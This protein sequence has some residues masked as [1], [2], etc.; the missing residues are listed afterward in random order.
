MDFKSFV[1]VGYAT[2]PKASPVHLEPPGLS[3]RGPFEPFDVSVRG[4]VDRHLGPGRFCAFGDPLA[5]G[6]G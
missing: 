3:F 5:G 6:S 4:G 2:R 1:L